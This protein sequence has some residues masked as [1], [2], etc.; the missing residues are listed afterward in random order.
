MKRILVAGPTGLIGKTVVEQLLARRGVE[1]VALTRR[2][3]EKEGGGIEQWIAPSNDLLAGLKDEHVDAVICCLGTT[4]K[5]AGS[6]EKFRYVDHDLVVGIGKWAKQQRVPVFCVVSAMGADPRSKIF[7]NRVKGEME[8]DLKGLNLPALHIFHPSILTGPREE[9]RVGERIGIVAMNL[10][11]PL[12]LGPLRPYR[13]MPH[14][15]LAKAL[16]AAAAD[17]S[18]GVHVHEYQAIFELAGRN[19]S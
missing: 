12:M 6:Q 17:D 16:I 15:V 18:P 9:N 7:Y 14:D 10:L 3:L 1:V 2:S 8:K 4:I 13:P 19:A 5:T 11:K